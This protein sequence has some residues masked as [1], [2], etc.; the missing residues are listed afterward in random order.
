MDVQ[1]GTNSWNSKSSQCPKLWFWLCLRHSDDLNLRCWAPLI[2]AVGFSL[3][4]WLHSC[5]TEKNPPHLTR[6]FKTQRKIVSGWIIRIPFSM[7]NRFGA[8]SCE[9][10]YTSC[11]WHGHAND[12]WL[13]ISTYPTCKSSFKWIPFNFPSTKLFCRPASVRHQRSHDIFL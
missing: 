1:L 8:L 11:L 9:R 12:L 3:W 13:G 10:Q 7:Q 5:M 4:K 2:T 6:T